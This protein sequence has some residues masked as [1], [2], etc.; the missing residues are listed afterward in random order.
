MQRT[1][2]VLQLVISFIHKFYPDN[3]QLWVKGFIEESI[4]AYI[5]S[6]NK[7]SCSKGV[8]E[9]SI[10][11]LRGIDSDLDSIFAPAEGKL[12]FVNWLKTWN[13]SEVKD[14]VKP[15]LAKQLISKGIN[16]ESNAEDV[17]KTFGQIATEEL[18]KQGLGNDENLSLIHISEPTRPY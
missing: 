14:E 2:R 10:T 13:L 3:L 12:L 1:N 5:N 8:K 17:V 11:G 7:I 6:I 9:R 16:G 18:Q 4:V 15:A